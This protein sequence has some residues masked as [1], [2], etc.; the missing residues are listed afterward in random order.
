MISEFLVYFR[1]GIEHIL[2]VRGYDHIVFIVALTAPYRPRAWRQV[3]ILVTAFTV[4]H[5]LTLALATVDRV[6]VPGAWVEFL[7]PVTILLTALLHLWGLRSGSAAG[8]PTAAGGPRVP[9]DLRGGVREGPSGALDRSWDDALHPGGGRRVA[10]V[11]AL[12]F[13]LIHGLGFS[14]FLRAALGGDASIL[15]PLFAFNVG[16]EVGQVAVVAGVLAVGTAV[17]GPLGWT[18]SRWV[19]L[20][21]GA[22]AMVAVYL[23]VQRVPL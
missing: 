5:S 2:D 11:L 9:G 17:T 14:N 16:L 1:L 20:V 12:V 3:V 4:G 19:G 21:S 15:G 6:R 23:V 10:Y 22:I 8:P 7:I 18:R 13:G